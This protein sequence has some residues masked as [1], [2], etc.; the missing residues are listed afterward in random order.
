MRNGASNTVGVLRATRMCQ[1]ETVGNPLVQPCRLPELW[2]F[3]T[4]VWE[5]QAVDIVVVSEGFRLLCLGLSFF[6]H[7]RP[8][9]MR[10]SSSVLYERKC[11]FVLRL[12]LCINVTC[13]VRT[14]RECRGIICY[15]QILYWWFYALCLW[16]ASEGLRGPLVTA[17]CN[18]P[19]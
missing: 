6:R 14:G 10:T 3:A 17:G 5:M 1:E 19:S 18:V 4:C 2:R 15:P 8:T 12:R 7:E 9:F 11:T 16:K 13:G